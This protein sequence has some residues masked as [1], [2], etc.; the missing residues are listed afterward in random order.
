MSEAV[1]AS[2]GTATLDWV[3]LLVR[4]DAGGTGA[5]GSAVTG[6]WAGAW[7]VRLESAAMR[8]ETAALSLADVPA[9]RLRACL[10]GLTESDAGLLAGVAML[11]A[12]DGAAGAATGTGAGAAIGGL[13]AVMTGLACDEPALA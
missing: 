7:L 9:G 1:V 2:D 10:I 5:A 11:L 13:L 6:C 4:L 8:A 12:S 3:L